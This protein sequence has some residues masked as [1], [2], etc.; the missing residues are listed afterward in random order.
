MYIYGGEKI[1]TKKLPDKVRLIEQI[2]PT[3]NDGL[4][5]LKFN[6]CSA[7]FYYICDILISIK[8]DY[9]IC[10]IIIIY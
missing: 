10:F 2:L 8:F 5:H 6:I 1:L 9:K 3:L 4:D 7:P